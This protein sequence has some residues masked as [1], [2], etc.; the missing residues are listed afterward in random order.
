MRSTSEYIYSTLFE[1]G[2][3]SDVTIVALGMRVCVCPV[4]NLCLHVLVRPKSCCHG[5]IL[6]NLV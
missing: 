2:V 1:E 6:C 3:N 5:N 4:R